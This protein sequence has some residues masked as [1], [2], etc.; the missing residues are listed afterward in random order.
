MFNQGKTLVGL[1]F[2]EYYESRFSEDVMS[3]PQA[4][5]VVFIRAIGKE[6]AKNSEYASKL[7]QGLIE[8]YSG[9]LIVLETVLSKTSFESTYGISV[10]THLTLQKKEEDNWLL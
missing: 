9:S 1:S 8:F 4:S 6:P 2:P 10:V 3:K 7:L 5:Q